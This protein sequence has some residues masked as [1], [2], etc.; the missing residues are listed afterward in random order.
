MVGGRIVA[1][2]PKS[3]RV[4]ITVADKPYGRHEFCGVDIAPTDYPVKLGDSLWW[5]SGKCYWTPKG[6]VPEALKG[7]EDIPI[8]KIGYSYSVDR[9]V[10]LDLPEFVL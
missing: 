9:P 10:T 5:Q 2:R 3:D 7:R 1:I 6:N 4:C 8:P